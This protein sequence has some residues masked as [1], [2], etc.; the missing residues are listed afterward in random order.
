MTVLGEDDGT[1]ASSTDDGA[2]TQQYGFGWTARHFHPKWDGH[3]A[4]KE[5]FIQRMK[6]DNI[7]GIQGD[8]QEVS[9][10]P[11]STPAPPAITSLPSATSMS[12][13]PVLF[14]QTTQAC[15]GLANN[16]YIARDDAQDMIEN[17]FGVEASQLGPIERKY[18]EG[19]PEEM[20]IRFAANWGVRPGIDACSKNLLTLII[21][22][23]DGDNPQNPMNYKGGGNTTWADEV[24]EIL[25]LYQAASCTE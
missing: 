7:P 23:C 1:N 10:S 19:T 4:I 21:D 15:Y 9:S 18:N 20:T 25:P 11:S 5:S 8:S 2:Q 12:D 3:Q 22:D 17:H 6:D 16:K 24:Y 14:P 13:T